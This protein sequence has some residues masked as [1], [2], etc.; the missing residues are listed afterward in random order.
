M[1]Q[2]VAMSPWSEVNSKEEAIGFKLH[3][4]VLSSNYILF[5]ARL[6]S[7]DYY[8]SQ[9]GHRAQGSYCQLLLCS[10]DYGNWRVLSRRKPSGCELEK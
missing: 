8:S 3:G 4:K 9:S 1:A 10:L 2:H 7:L 5:R 6:I